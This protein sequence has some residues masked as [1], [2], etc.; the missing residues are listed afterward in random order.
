MSERII[1]FEGRRI[2]VPVDATDDEVSQ[3]LSSSAP[4]APA[5]GSPE[6]AAPVYPPA[7][8]PKQSLGDYAAETGAIGLRQGRG[9]LATVLGAPVDLVNAIMGSFLPQTVTPGT[10]QQDQAAAQAATS[11]DPGSPEG[12]V[13]VYPPRP[14]SQGAPVSKTPFMGADMIDA[15]LGSPNRVIAKATGMDP[16]RAAEGPQPRDAFQRVIG[17]IGKE[18]GANV[19]P[20]AGAIAGGARVGAQGARVMQNQGVGSGILGKMFEAGAVNPAGLAGRETAYAG[21]AGLGAG[22]ANEWVGNPQNGDNFWSDFLGSLAGVVGANVA[23]GMLRGTAGVGNAL[24]GKEAFRTGVAEQAVAE[25]ILTNSSRM[26]QQYAQRGATDR[27]DTTD[28]VRDLRR[29]SAAEEAIPGFRANIADRAQDPGL[30]T[31]AL[32]REGGAPGAARNRRVENQEAID[33][34]MTQMDPS[35][36]P[37][38]FRAA[39][40]TNRASRIAAVDD[41]VQQAQARFDEAVRAIEPVNANAE[42]RGATIRSGVDNAERAARDV[43]RAAYRDFNGAVEPAPVAEAFQRVADG[44]PQAYR[45]LVAEVQDALSIP[46]NATGPLDMREVVAIRSRLTTAQRN[47]GSGPQPDTNK[48]RVI[49][50]FVD[51]LDDATA[52][53]L[54][55]EAL[56]KWEQARAI[57]RDVNERF[58][59]P[60]DPLAA[61]ISRRE[62]RPDVPDSGVGQRFIQ[63]D[64]GQASNINRVLAETDLTAEGGPVFGALQDELRADALRRGVA[65]KPENAEAFVRDYGTASDRLGVKTDIEQVGQTGRVAREAERV[66]ETTRR[67]LTTPTRSP[68]ANYLQYGDEATVDAVNAVT[69]SPTAREDMRRL[70]ESAG[71]TPEARRNARAALW[72]VVKRQRNDGKTG[73]EWSGRKLRAMFDNPKTLA[74]AREAWA[75]DPEDL[76]NIRKVFDALA[77]SERSTGSQVPGTSGTGGQLLSQGFDARSVSSSIR[78][79]NQGR[80][81]ITSEFL[82]QAQGRLRQMSA[83]AQKGAIED[84]TNQVINNPGLAAD[85]LQKYNPVDFAAKGRMISQKYGLRTS[86]F[87]NMLDE[88]NDPDAETKR[89]I[90]RPGNE[91]R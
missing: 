78:S 73:P 71:G 63:P 3:I 57:S 21:A 35:G 10:V 24:M 6:G 52:R 77:K 19:L 34:R 2:R 82:Y 53:G 7:P 55:A 90:T 29:P 51:A 36:D 23:G 69:T 44:I 84:L 42:A 75:D 13:P 66:A 81:S 80:S 56:S 15:I 76:D 68:E 25:D 88:E 27:I 54:P 11:A 85:L 64:R 37:A 1:N 60:N 89:A 47:A 8:P 14:V 28:L 48:A 72:E 50:D 26:Q 43:E 9:G 86:A 45:P 4:A 31:F 65:K 17:R 39:L 49:G 87:F 58:N 16:N 79:V 67:D 33:Y 74:A 46:S 20:L 70:I 91:P 62:G 61:V 41:N 59:R 30:D 83:K 22:A 5:A 12:A 18:M 40:E 38:Q 32:N